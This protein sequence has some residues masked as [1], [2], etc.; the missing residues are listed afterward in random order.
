MPAGIGGIDPRAEQDEIRGMAEWGAL[1]K[2]G[3]F[4]IVPGPTCNTRIGR[5][6]P[7]VTC[8][9]NRAT[10]QAAPGGPAGVES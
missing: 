6:R 9:G 2:T 5:L 7:R 1:T 10:R 4:P 8:A 3:I